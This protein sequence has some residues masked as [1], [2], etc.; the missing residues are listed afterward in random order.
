MGQVVYNLL[1]NAVKF[2]SDGGSIS[3]RVTRQRDRT[4]VTVR[5]TGEG[6]PAEEMPHIFDRFYKSDRS[7]SRDKVGVG[8]GLFLV[9]S[10]ISLHRGEICVRSVTGEYAE[11]EFWL[12]LTRLSASLV[13]ETAEKISRKSHN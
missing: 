8:L 3:L 7:R 4:V 9:K 2:T 1:D 11:F 10:I 5:N 13:H 12:P 6:I